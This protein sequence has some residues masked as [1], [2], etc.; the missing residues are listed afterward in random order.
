MFKGSYFK[1]YLFPVILIMFITA[2]QSDV[3]SY[4]VLD[5]TITITIIDIVHSQFL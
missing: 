4:V 2:F 5:F 1:K 3:L